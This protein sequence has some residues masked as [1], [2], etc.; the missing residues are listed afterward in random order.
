MEIIIKNYPQSTR[1]GISKLTKERIANQLKDVNII[2]RDD[3]GFKTHDLVLYPFV[4]DNLNTIFEFET[5]QKI[6]KKSEEKLKRAILRELEKHITFEFS[7]ERLAEL[8]ISELEHAGIY[9]LMDKMNYKPN[10]LLAIDNT[11]IQ[12]IATPS[13][14]L[15]DKIFKDWKNMIRL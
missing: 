13:G 12:I 11:T 2:V 14:T 5:P 10:P 9:K 3:F 1:R 4:K 8:M 7:E 6:R 15:Q